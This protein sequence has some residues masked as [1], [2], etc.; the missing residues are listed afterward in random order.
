VLDLVLVGTEFGVEAE[1][2]VLLSLNHKGHWIGAYLGHY[3]REKILGYPS[4]YY[5]SAVY[6]CSSY[7][8]NVPVASRA[9]KTHLIRGIPKNG[10]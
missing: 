7:D 6:V 4:G 9:M 10:W 5:F 8:V 2:R 3:W 1:K